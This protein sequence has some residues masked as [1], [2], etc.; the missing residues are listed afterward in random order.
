MKL[1]IKKKEGVVEFFK[2]LGGE[3]L[4]CSVQTWKN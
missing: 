4:D 1:V 3:I 2:D